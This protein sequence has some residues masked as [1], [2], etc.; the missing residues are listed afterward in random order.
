MD[1]N[2]GR[3][4]FHRGRRGPDRRGHDRR[5][6]QQQ[7]A[8]QEHGGSRN[9]VD[10]E[11]IM[12][13]IRARIA[14]RGGVE[15]TNQQ[16]QDLAAR[17]LESILDPRSIN[18]TLLDELRRA[19]GTSS[20]APP[21]AP[22]PVYAFDDET[23]F[24]SHNAVTRFFR[25]LLRPILM[26]FFNPT[27]VVRALK[28]Q[29]SFNTDLATRE[30]E[31]ERRQ[32]EWNALHYELVQ[33]LVLEVSRVSL[34][35]QA[36]LMK[37][38]SLS[39]KVDFNERRVRGVEGSIHQARPAP[40]RE[41]AVEAPAA[42]AAAVVPEP[43]APESSGGQP[44]PAGEATRRRRRRRRGRRSGGGAA[45]ATVAAAEGTSLEAESDLPEGDDGVDDDEVT[46][47]SGDE[48]S[49]VVADALA[50]SEIPVSEAASM[51]PVTV[52]PQ[53]VPDPMPTPAAPPDGPER[54]EQEPPER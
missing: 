46:A 41:P 10:V 21:R 27:P 35:N 38:E 53:A 31:R 1:H 34:D 44:A 24:E 9:D 40:R 48:D 19:T 20:Q 49:P 15:L 39:A 8:A 51:P 18:P 28:T 43:G 22:E 54:H 16:I 3:R 52:T 42:A 14:Q 4:H 30:A 36:L 50:A 12:R 26:L 17:R 32:T 6:Q 25:R 13:D 23:I 5:A 2:Q 37:V 47:G 29:A 33:K 45:D 11:Q 7:Q